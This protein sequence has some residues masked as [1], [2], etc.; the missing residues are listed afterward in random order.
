METENSGS[1]APLLEKDQ[2]IEYAAEL[3]KYVNIIPYK[4]ETYFRLERSRLKENY[5]NLRTFSKG[6]P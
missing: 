4:L 1:S 6:K 3:K 2:V 5:N